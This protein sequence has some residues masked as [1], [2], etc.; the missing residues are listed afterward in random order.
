MTRMACGNYYFLYQELT[1]VIKLQPFLSRA[2]CSLR[3]LFDLKTDN[4][5]GQNGRVGKICSH[6]LSEPHQL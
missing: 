2:L 6:L 3:D 5:S 1:A 4:I